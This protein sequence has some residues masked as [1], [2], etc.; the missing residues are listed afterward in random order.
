MSQTENAPKSAVGQFFHEMDE[1][2]RRQGSV[3]FALIFKEFKT[4]SKRASLNNMAW[5]V[6]EPG[7]QIMIMAAFWYVL[8]VQE[9]GGVHIAMFL[10]ISM[11]PFA[12]IQRSIS[13]IPRTLR[14]NEAFYSYQQV[15][16]IDS[17]IARFFLD[18]LLLL[19]GGLVM[20]FLLGWFLDLY[21]NTDKLLQFLGV[22][23]LASALGFGVALT[24][25]TYSAIY[26]GISRTI[27]M[28]N[29]GL[30]LV[31]AVIHQVSQLPT[32]AQYYISWNPIAHLTEFARYYALGLKP[33]PGAS[34]GYVLLVT[35][36]FLFLGFVSYYANRFRLL[37]K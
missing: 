33:F 1:G 36:S 2:M 37:K 9:I 28:M 21:I 30:L 18:W 19:V 22:I 23:V 26:E 3:V 15:K 20:L 7:I 29:R 24:V 35:V 12:I 13:S 27:Q 10:L 32:N 17:V 8:R 14:A 16:P 4:K 31:S 34:M 11:M 25:A 6:L 5:V